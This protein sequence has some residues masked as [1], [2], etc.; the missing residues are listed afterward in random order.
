MGEGWDG[1]G[2]VNRRSPPHPDPPPQRGEGEYIEFLAE[3]KMCRYQCLCGGGSDFGELSRP[4][5]GGVSVSWLATPTLTLPHPGGGNSNS[6][7]CLSSL[8]S[9]SHRCGVGGSPSRRINPTIHSADAPAR[10]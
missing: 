4:G 3:S 1:G 10:G 7:V 8:Q 5:W 9:C 6:R 2:S